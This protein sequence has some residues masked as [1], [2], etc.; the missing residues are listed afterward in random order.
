MNVP[1]VACNS[2]RQIARRLQADVRQWLIAFLKTTHIYHFLDRSMWSVT[3]KNDVHAFHRLDEI[4]E[5]ALKQPPSREIR[6]FVEV[7]MDQVIP[8]IADCRDCLV[9]HGSRT[10]G[11]R[12]AC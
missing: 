6:E 7:Y 4:L 2:T 12:L 1:R 10:Q 11:A 9:R 5:V 8:E 3:L